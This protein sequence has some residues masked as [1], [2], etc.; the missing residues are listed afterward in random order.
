KEV[1]FRL[2]AATNKDLEEMVR[3]GEFRQDLF[4][5]LNVIPIH[6]PPLR[7]RKDDVSMFIH[8]YKTQ[9][10]EKYGMDK[11]FH[12]STI[13]AL[14]QYEWPGNVRELENLIERLILTSETN[15][16]YPTDLPFEQAEFMA[17]QI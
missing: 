2:V 13:K 14:L 10:N 9:F 5:R 12:P 17:G 6:I 3:R 8:H 7:E 1:D 4:Y 16:I 15:V 11:A